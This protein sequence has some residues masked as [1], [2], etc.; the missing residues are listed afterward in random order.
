M[1][2][3]YSERFLRDQP[4][5]YKRERLYGAYEQKT[6]SNLIRLVEEKTE[7]RENDPKLLPTATVFEFSEQISTQTTLYKNIINIKLMEETIKRKYYESRNIYTNSKCLS[8]IGC[9]YTT[10]SMPTDVS[11]CVRSIVKFIEVFHL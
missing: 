8:I 4:A 7:M 1:N 6:L 11:H 2:T 3:A 10:I 9:T 5:H